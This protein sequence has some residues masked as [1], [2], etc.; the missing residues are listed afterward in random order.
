ML[1]DTLEMTNTLG[2]IVGERKG[3]AL[4]D[5]EFGARLDDLVQLLRLCLLCNIDG[6]YLGYGGCACFRVAVVVLPLLLWRF[7][8]LAPSVQ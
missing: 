4:D 6:K 1:L 7:I 2:A 3:N 5:L 8:A